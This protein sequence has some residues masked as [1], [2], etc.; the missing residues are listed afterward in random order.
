MMKNLF[1]FSKDYTLKDN[2]IIKEGYL[3]KESR[4]LKNWRE[5]WTVL[6]DKYLLTFENEKVYTNATEVIEINSIR[7]VKS[8]DNPLSFIFKVD[9]TE[10]TFFFQAKSFDEKESWIGAIGKIMV[11]GSKKNIYIEEED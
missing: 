1:G 5:R 10:G 9:S 6:S 4:I 8:D 7:T 2:E 3:L 11:Q